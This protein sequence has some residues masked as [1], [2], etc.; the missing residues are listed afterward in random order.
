VIR[1]YIVYINGDD[2]ND[3]EKDDDDA[4]DNGDDNR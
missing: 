1:H 2:E 3:I 4:K